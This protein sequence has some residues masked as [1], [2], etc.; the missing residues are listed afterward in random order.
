MDR[1]KAQHLDCRTRI[2]RRHLEEQNRQK[3][4][5]LEPGTDQTDGPI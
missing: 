2:S 4:S 5:A 3:R 1:A